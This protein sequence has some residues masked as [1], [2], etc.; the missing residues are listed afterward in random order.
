MRIETFVSPLTLGA[1][2][3]YDGWWPNRSNDFAANESHKYGTLEGTALATTSFGGQAAGTKQ[4]Y[5]SRLCVNLGST[6]ATLGYS[7]FNNVPWLGPTEAPAASFAHDFAVLSF[8]ACLATDLT[9]TRNI[10]LG[11]QLLAAAGTNPV[12]KGPGAGVQFGP[13]SQTEVGLQMRFANA[14]AITYQSFKTPAGFDCRDWHKYEIRVVSSSTA[15]VQGTVAAY[16]DDVLFD[17][18][19]NIDATTAKFPP[20]NASSSQGYQAGIINVSTAL[21]PNLYAAWM[22]WIVAPNESTLP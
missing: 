8:S 2:R 3:S 18:K 12:Y 16:L 21:V 19:V 17:V 11:I 14:G 10:D 20:P 13:T 6:G 7:L 22:H 5:R 9:P 4:L 1:G 15:G